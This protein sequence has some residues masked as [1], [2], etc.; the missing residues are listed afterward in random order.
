MGALAASLPV[1]GCAPPPPAS[2]TAAAPSGSAQ[3]VLVASAPGPAQP[4]SGAAASGA[5][6]SGAQAPPVAKALPSDERATRERVVVVSSNP[7]APPQPIMFTLN[8]DTFAPGAKAILEEVIQ[9]LNDNPAVRIAIE[10]HTHPKIPRALSQALAAR[11]ALRVRDFL[12]AGG[13]DAGRLT[14]LSAGSRCA[15]AAVADLSHLAENERVELYI[16]HPQPVAQPPQA[17]CADVEP[18]E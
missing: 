4:P 16:T 1:A 18:A 11:R 15:K 10:G 2:P 13:I 6:A 9:V 3:L 5:E 17:R 8:K 12:V 7:P 14:P